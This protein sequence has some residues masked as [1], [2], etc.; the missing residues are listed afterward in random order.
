MGLVWQPAYCTSAVRV[1]RS[2]STSKFRVGGR[3]LRAGRP[4]I[5]YLLGTAVAEHLLGI[6]AT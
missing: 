6:P 5:Q 3:W 1:L 4:C 2:C